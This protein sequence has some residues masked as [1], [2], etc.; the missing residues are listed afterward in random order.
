[1]KNL[2]MGAAKGYGWNDVEPF[3]IS[4]KKNCPSADLVLFVD[5][6]SVFTQSILKSISGLKLVQIPATFQNTLVI[7]ARW[8]MYKNYIAEHPEYKNIFVTDVRDVIF[9]SDIFNCRKEKNFLL[10]A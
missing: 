3:V 9:Q 10:Y 5:D 7:D 6:I 2:I 8:T 4:C 1:M